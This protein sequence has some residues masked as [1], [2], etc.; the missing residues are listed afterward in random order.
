[1]ELKEWTVQ[2]AKRLQ[3]QQHLANPAPVA[4]FSEQYLYLPGSISTWAE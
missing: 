4:A 2:G 3:S 1:L